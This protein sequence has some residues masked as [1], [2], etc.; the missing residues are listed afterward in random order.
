[1]VSK[2][3]RVIIFII[4]TW[5]V[6]NVAFLV[7]APVIMLWGDEPLIETLWADISFIPE[8]IY[9]VLTTPGSHTEAAII[10][11]FGFIYLFPLCYWC[12]RQT[13]LRA[14][15]LSMFGL[16]IGPGIEFFFG[17][18][19]T[20][21]VLVGV[22]LLVGLNVFYL[23]LYLGAKYQEKYGLHNRVLNFFRFILTWPCFKT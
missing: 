23:I 5:G 3:I 1:M 6:I 18:I 15:A 10:W 4:Y 2:A 8:K 9:I 21:L 19:K 22:R 11:F 14:W 17:I 12:D 16:F 20:E 13:L 7:S